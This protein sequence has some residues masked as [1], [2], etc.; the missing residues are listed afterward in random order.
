MPPENNLFIESQSNGLKQSMPFSMAAK[1]EELDED[2]RGESKFGVFLRWSR[3]SK[4]VSIKPENQ[5]LMRGSIIDL[6]PQS[7]EDFRTRMLKISSGGIH[8]RSKK[9]VKTILNEVSGYA[10]PGEILAMMG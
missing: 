2:E 1:H 8:E 9:H 10:A 5:G 7:R 6:T 3:I 4:S